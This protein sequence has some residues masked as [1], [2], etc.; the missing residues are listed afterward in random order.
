MRDT[1]VT[2][3]IL[4]EIENMSTLVNSA[5]CVIQVSWRLRALQF[6]G[7]TDASKNS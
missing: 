2:F 7:A 5:I 4:M 6:G 1:V 3:W